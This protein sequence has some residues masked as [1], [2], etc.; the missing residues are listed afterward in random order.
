MGLRSNEGFLERIAQISYNVRWYWGH[1]NLAARAELN[2]SQQ[3][4]LRILLDGIGTS[5]KF[6][7]QVLT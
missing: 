1:R 5:K 7:E 3:A 6:Y 2:W 4:H